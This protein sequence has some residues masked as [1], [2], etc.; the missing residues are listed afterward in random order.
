MKK[1]LYII[2]LFVF[3]LL[4][5]CTSTKELTKVIAN[6]NPE[7]GPRQRLE[8]ANK[9]YGEGDFYKAIQLY[10]IVIQ[11]RIMVD[12]LAEVYFRFANSHFAQYDYITA[13]SLFNSFYITYPDNVNAEQA[14]FYRAV[15]TYEI[16]EN[17]F[18]LDQST[19]IQA[20]KQFQDY[21]IT[22]PEGEFAT[23]SIDLIEDIKNT[24][25]AKELNTGKLYYQIGEY[26]AAIEEFE[27]FIETYPTS[28][29]VEEAY[30]EILQSRIDL[31][32]N[33][34]EAKK[35]ERFEK[36]TEEVGYF[37][38]KYSFGPYAAQ[39]QSIKSEAEK[40]LENYKEN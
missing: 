40:E 8:L 5:S 10:E 24:N 26:K 16:A 29:L 14:Y 9:Y 22:Y 13:S 37:M 32:K 6:D 2:Y 3:A 27:R 36:V 38:E 17:D 21:L 33:S 18:R 25:E 39:A 34:I 11:E 31:A 15:C 23:E 4:L 30:Y 35:Q 1:R 12:D 7:E 20:M 28:G 19:I